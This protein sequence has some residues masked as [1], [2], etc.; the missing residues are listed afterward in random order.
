VQYNLKRKQ[1]VIRLFEVGKVYRRDK[2]SFYEPEKIGLWLAGVKTLPSWDEK[3]SKVAFSDLYGIVEEL[4]TSRGITLLLPEEDHHE[5]YSGRIKLQSEN[6]THGH[7]GQV[8]P[9]VLEFFGIRE[10]VFFAEL[11]LK[12]LLKTQNLPLYDAPSKYPPISRDISLA[13]A[14]QTTFA[15]IQQ[16]I[17]EEA[18]PEL[19]QLQLI[20]YYKSPALGEDKKS[21]TIRL[22][23]QSKHK[24]LS[25]KEVNKMADILEKSLTER[26]KTTIRN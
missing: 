17:T 18:I 21:Y 26:L 2:D 14:K 10:P 4:M 9:S 8:A 15:E 25:D 5:H 7:I 1:E 22:T 20:D 12:P 23:F 24:T 13:V 16:V 6:G 19:Q 11:H 3:A